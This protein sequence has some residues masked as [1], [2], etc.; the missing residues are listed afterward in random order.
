MSYS[1]RY[2]GISWMLF[3]EAHIYKYM[4]YLNVYTS[5]F[6]TFFQQTQAPTICQLA[7]WVSFQHRQYFNWPSRQPCIPPLGQAPNCQS[8][9]LRDKGTQEIS[10][11]K[12]ISY[13]KYKYIYINYK[14]LYIYIYIQYSLFKSLPPKTT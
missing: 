9:G 5:G 7:F 3:E 4:K 8:T 14:L 13:D 12:L 11:S 1:P 2:V 10:L 6:R